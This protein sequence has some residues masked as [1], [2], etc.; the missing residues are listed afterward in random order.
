MKLPSGDMLGAKET[1]V[2]TMDLVLVGNKSVFLR[3]T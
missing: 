1:E 3:N 2:N